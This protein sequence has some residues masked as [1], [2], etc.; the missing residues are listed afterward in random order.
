[1]TDADLKARI[2]ARFGADR[3][4]TS[5]QARW[6]DYDLNPHAL[7]A[8][9]KARKLR[10]AAVLVPLVERPDALTLLLTQRT[11]HLSAHAGQIS[12]PGGRREAQDPHATATA[13]REAEEEVGIKPEEVRVVGAMDAYETRTGFLVTP[14]IGLVRPDYTVN[15]D[16]FEVEEAFEVPLR[17]LLDAAN[18]KRH[19][20]EHQGV[21][22]YFHAM[23][24]GDY[25]IWGATAGMLMNLYRELMG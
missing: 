21:T 22:Y 25:Y 16:P 9:P 1:M 17:F 23:P 4:E 11:S 15:I 24:Y 7:G 20:L 18:H 3:G 19:S 13:L 2:E 10:E 8:R 5:A 6:S 12:F 14:V